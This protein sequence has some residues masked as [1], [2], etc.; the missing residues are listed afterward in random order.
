MTSREFVI[1]FSTSHGSGEIDKEASDV[2]TLLE[3]TETTGYSSPIGAS[4]AVQQP[5]Y[6]G[7][8]PLC[9]DLPPNLSECWSDVI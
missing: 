1:D 7:Q 2:I 9:P 3:R 6:N 5:R 8:L 4:R